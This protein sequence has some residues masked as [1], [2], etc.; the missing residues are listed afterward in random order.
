M[1]VKAV[2]SN[3]SSEFQIARFPPTRWLYNI[4]QLDQNLVSFVRAL[5]QLDPDLVISIHPLCQ[6]VPLKAL[7]LVGGG[8]RVIPFVTV[9][10]DLGGAHP[11]VS[12]SS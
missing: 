3:D 4:M 11:L 12:A 2:F 5:E 6:T 9:V 1:H 7:N 8:K 10:T